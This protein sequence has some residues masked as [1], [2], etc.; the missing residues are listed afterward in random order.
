MSGPVG[1]LCLVSPLFIYPLAWVIE[2][3]LPI[4]GVMDFLR[5]GF[6][7]LP[8]FRFSVSPKSFSRSFLPIYFTE[9]E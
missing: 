5:H 4:N 2:I 7:G 6:F 1:C 8:I 3:I 9:I